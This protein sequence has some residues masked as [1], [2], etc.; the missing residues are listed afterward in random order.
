MNRFEQL[1]GAGTS[2]TDGCVEKLLQN[3][4]AWKPEGGRL[5]QLA[6]F[7]ARRFIVILRQSLVLNC[8]KHQRIRDTGD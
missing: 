2:D 4:C 6:D 1:R 7:V 3:C 8:W 5:K